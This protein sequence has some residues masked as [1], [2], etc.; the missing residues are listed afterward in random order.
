VSGASGLG[1]AAM[2]MPMA[3]AYGLCLWPMPMG[4]AYGLC[5][6][7]MRMVQ[8]LCDPDGISLWCGVDLLRWESLRVGL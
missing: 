4:Y 8:G 1:A 6:W 2:P 7:P 5:L 3:Y